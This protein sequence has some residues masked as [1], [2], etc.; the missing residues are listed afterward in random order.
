MA[1]RCGPEWVRAEI[2]KI[3]AENYARF[4][5]P[6]PDVAD[7]LPEIVGEEKVDAGD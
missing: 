3:L 6:E 7:E 2:S 4:A 5:E 1:S